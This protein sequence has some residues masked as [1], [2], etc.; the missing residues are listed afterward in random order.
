[1]TFI[2]V[3]KKKTFVFLLE[4]R[5]EEEEDKRQSML[6][7]MKAKRPKAQMK[8]IKQLG[9]VCMELCASICKGHISGFKLE[10][11]SSRE[12]WWSPFKENLHQ[13]DLLAPELRQKDN[14]HATDFLCNRSESLTLK[15]D[16]EPVG[17]HLSDWCLAER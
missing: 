7:Q 4:K 13:S 6:A 16:A 10:K 3:K 9:T 12:P 14:L 15:R 1:M 5:A 17:F 8:V 2:S 11:C